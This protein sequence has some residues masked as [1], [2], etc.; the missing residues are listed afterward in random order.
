MSVVAVF[1]VHVLTA[2]MPRQL[3]F[4]NSQQKSVRPAMAPF[5]S[6]VKWF[7]ARKGYGFLVH[8]ETGEDVFIH[9]SNIDVDK[10]FKTL[11]TGQEVEYDVEDGPKG[12]HA[13]SIRPLDG[14]G[15][16]P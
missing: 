16:M 8:E 15:D 3:F 1:L 6:V 5:R 2:A 9:Y 10:R 7:D 14:L 11:R 12:L 4:R 13:I